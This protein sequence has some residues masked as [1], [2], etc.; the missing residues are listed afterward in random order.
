LL[1]ILREVA[2]RIKAGDYVV[3]ITNVSGHEEMPGDNGTY[4]TLTLEIVAGDYRGKKFALDFPIGS[5]SKTRIGG[6]SI[7]DI[8]WRDLTVIGAAIGVSGGDSDVLLHKP[9]MVRV[10]SDHRVRAFYP[11]ARG[12]P[13]LIHSITEVAA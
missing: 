13:R 3:E 11:A 8:A 7:N 1:P 5:H 9:F 6:R 12:M 4:V 2:G 10:G